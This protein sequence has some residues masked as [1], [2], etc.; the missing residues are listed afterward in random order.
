[1]H[2]GCHRCIKKESYDMIDR[3]RPPPR[4]PWL[5][6]PAPSRPPHAIAA[7]LNVGLLSFNTLVYFRTSTVWPS[8]YTCIMIC[9]KIFRPLCS[10]S[11]PAVL[12]QHVKRI[13]LWCR[14]NPLVLTN[15]RGLGS[16]SPMQQPPWRGSEPSEIHS[17]ASTLLQSNGADNSALRYLSSPGVVH[18]NATCFNTDDLSDLL[19]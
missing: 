5:G 7:P 9:N 13:C 8:W 3:H 1:M 18:Y 10:S 12:E 15:N 16:E 17:V 19:G 6:N 4:Q 11:K 14:R 2:K